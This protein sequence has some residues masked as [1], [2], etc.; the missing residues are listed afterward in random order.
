MTNSRASEVEFSSLASCLKL[1]DQNVASAMHP[2][3]PEKHGSLL[4]FRLHPW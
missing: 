1:P 4:W 3:K 2:V